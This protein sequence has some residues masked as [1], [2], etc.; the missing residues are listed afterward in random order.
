MVLRTDSNSMVRPGGYGTGHGQQGTEFERAAIELLSIP[1]IAFGAGVAGGTSLDEEK[2]Y[3]NNMDTAPTVL[4]ALGLEPL[5]NC[6]GQTVVEAFTAGRTG[7]GESGLLGV[8]VALLA[9]GAIGWVAR[10]KLGQKPAADADVS[11]KEMLVGE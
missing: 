9:G 11:E 4:W 6:R 5:A 1:W 10:V 3:V 8:V 7:T 2:R